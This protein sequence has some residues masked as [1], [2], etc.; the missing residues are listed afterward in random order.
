MNTIELRWLWMRQ[1]PPKVEDD[2]VALQYRQRAP[3]P[4]GVR[5]QLERGIATETVWG[6]WV[7]VPDEGLQ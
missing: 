7:T 5:H 4:E 2:I 6:P 3:L 1:D